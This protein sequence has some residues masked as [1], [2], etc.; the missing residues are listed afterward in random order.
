MPGGYRKIAWH[1]LWLAGAA[2][3]LVFMSCWGIPSPADAV[4]AEP[5][6]QLTPDKNRYFL[7]PVLAYL[8][9][10]QK[11]FAIDD[12][13]SPQMTVGLPRRS[14]EYYQRDSIHSQAPRMLSCHPRALLNPLHS[15][16]DLRVQKLRLCDCKFV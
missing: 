10:P 13:S 9:D 12:V 15:S 6:L 4:P 16:C 7:G 8:E 2:V 11:K 1:Y 14:D 3:I 5:I